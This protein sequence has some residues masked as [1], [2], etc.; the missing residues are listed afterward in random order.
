MCI[1]LCTLPT[2]SKR[3]AIVKYLKGSQLHPSGD[4]HCDSPGYSAK[5]CMY[6][7]MDSATTV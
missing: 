6:T 7:L 1:L 2:L 4:G 5:Y 3:E